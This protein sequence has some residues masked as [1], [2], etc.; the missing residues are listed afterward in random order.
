LAVSFL[1]NTELRKYA[2]LQEAQS[3]GKGSR[4]NIGSLQSHSFFPRSGVI[5]AYQSD[6][7]FGSINTGEHCRR[8]RKKCEPELARFL[9]ISLGSASELEYHIILSTDLSYINKPTSHH[10]ANQ[11]T[12]VKRMLTALIQKLTTES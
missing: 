3:L 5:W 4:V 11:V 2:G 12:E 10:L 9:R 1:L 8:L 6:E 7:T